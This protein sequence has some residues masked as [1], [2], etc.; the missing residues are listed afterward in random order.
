MI[1]KKEHRTVSLDDS[2]SQAIELLVL[3]CSS[4][5]GLVWFGSIKMWFLKIKT[6]TETGGLSFGS[7]AE[8]LP[9]MRKALALRANRQRRKKERKREEEKCE[10]RE[11]G[12]EGRGRKERESYFLHITNYEGNTWPPNVMQQNPRFLLS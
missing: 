11:G 9:S 2:K 10:E 12:R 3:F 6:I 8:L 4:L 7:V 5:F 1:L